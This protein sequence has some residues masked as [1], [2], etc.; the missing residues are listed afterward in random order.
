LIPNCFYPVI[1]FHLP[2]T[3]H[4]R[5]SFDALCQ[6]MGLE[7]LDPCDASHATL[8][9]RSQVLEPDWPQYAGDGVAFAA[10]VS[11]AS[12][13]SPAHQPLERSGPDR[14]HQ[15]FTTPASC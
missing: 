12:L 2:C 3:F 9:R 8:Y 15:P 6:A 10:L 1:A 13:A 11:V 7:V 5:T 4:L 14:P